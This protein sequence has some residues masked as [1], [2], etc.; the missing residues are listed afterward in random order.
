MKNIL[1]LTLHNILCNIRV[2]CFKTLGE[3]KCTKIKKLI[4]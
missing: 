4:L 2:F 3:D 1:L